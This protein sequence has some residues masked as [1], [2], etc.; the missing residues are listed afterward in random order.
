[1]IDVIQIVGALMLVAV[2]AIG[3]MTVSTLN[4]IR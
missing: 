4:R 2:A 1:M 3:F